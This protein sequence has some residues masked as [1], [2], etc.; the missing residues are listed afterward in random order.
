LLL[1]L[2][3]LSGCGWVNSYRAIARSENRFAAGCRALESRDLAR[4]R[5]EFQAAVHDQPGAGH[6]Y[7]RI[8]FA[9]EYTG[10]YPEAIPWLERAVAREPDNPRLLNDLGYLY[11]ERGIRLPRAVALLERAVAKRPRDGNI[12]DSLGWAYYRQGRLEK[13][14]PLLE[15]AARLRREQ[16]ILDHR[17]IVR[18]S[19]E[20]RGGGP[21]PQ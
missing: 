19:L 5:Q 8:G 18:R 1:A 2:L 10:R 7:A 12:L 13:A 11:A 20:A 14:L 15:Q 9:Y 3:S 6:L 17:D 16:V 4:A 21:V